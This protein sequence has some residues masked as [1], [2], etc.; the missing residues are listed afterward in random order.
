MNKRDI[1]SVVDARTVD[2]AGRPSRGFEIFNG[3]MVLEHVLALAA[4]VR[5]VSDVVCLAPDRAQAAAL[6][7]SFN[8]KQNVHFHSVRDG[9]LIS[10][11]KRLIGLYKCSALLR[12]SGDNLLY[13]KRIVNAVVSEC[14]ATGKPAFFDI[15]GD[16]TVPPSAFGRVDAAPAAAV[17]EASTHDESHIAYNIYKLEVLCRRAGIIP[18]RYFPPHAAIVE[19][20]KI[21]FDANVFSLRCFD[22]EVTNMCNLRCRI[23]PYHGPERLSNIRRKPGYIDDCLFRAVCDELGALGRPMQMDFC[24]RGE[25]LLH[26]H[27]E[28]FIVYA[29]SHGII[30]TVVTNG[31]LLDINRARALCESGLDNISISI[32]A[33]KEETFRNI[34]GVPLRKVTDNVKGLLRMRDKMSNPLKI[35]VNFTLDE[36]NRNEAETFYRKWSKLADIVTFNEKR[37]ANGRILNRAAVRHTPRFACE[38][39]LTL[40]IM[41][42]DGT[43]TMCCIDGDAKYLNCGNAKN[44]GVIAALA[45]EKTRALY[46]KKPA[47]GN[48][49]PCKTCDLWKPPATIGQTINNSHI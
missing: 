32:D 3:R 12:L 47:S 29:K 27:L 36:N 23:C 31:L 39:P 21:N 5:E 13:S 30:P 35:A 4:S 44:G 7:K 37:G 33:V 25:T 18:V 2:G 20:H 34:R 46:S 48:G 19:L 17:L 26:P 43:I 16:T 22:V 9:K 24:H 14:R 28:D 49:I 10:T 11:Y 15:Y 45:S 40:P 38:M 1:L 6:S 41:L 42:L 8:R